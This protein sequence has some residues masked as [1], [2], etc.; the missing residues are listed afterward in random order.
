MS[1]CRRRRTASAI[2]CWDPYCDEPLHG[3]VFQYAPPP[4]AELCAQLEK[5]E[6]FVHRAADSRFEVLVERV[7]VLEAR[8]E[9][10]RVRQLEARLNQA[11]VDNSTHTTPGPGES[12]AA[13]PAAAPALATATAV[14]AATAAVTT[15]TPTIAPTVATDRPS[16][17]ATAAVTFAVEVALGLGDVVVVVVGAVNGVGIVDVGVVVVVH[18]FPGES[19]NMESLLAVESTQATAQRVCAKDDAP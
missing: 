10:E 18:I 3:S 2:V 7:R 1:K 15:A 5:R 16:S 19:G 11:F 17:V 12:C 8:L 13:P 14:P 6:E 4:L 9:V